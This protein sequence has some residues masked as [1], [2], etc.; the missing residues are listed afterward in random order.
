MR[1]GW[2]SAE[3]RTEVRLTF[4]LV[5]FQFFLE[6]QRRPHAEK[7]RH[8]KEAGDLHQRINEP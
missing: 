8:G 4:C 6:L 2:R 1:G 3:R 5:L 7:G